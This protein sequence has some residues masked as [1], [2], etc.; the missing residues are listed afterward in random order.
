MELLNAA[1]ALHPAF[2]EAAIIEMGAGVRPAFADNLPRIRRQGRTYFVNGFHRHGFLLAPAL[3]EMTA[4]T[5]L[6]GRNFPEVMDEDHRQRR[7]A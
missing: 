7:L 5:V 3:A 1:Y 2:G 4:Q 6:Q